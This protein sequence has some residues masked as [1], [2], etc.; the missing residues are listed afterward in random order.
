MLLK[1][2][3]ATFLGAGVVLLSSWQASSETKVKLRGII[4]FTNAVK[5]KPKTEEEI[6]KAIAPV[7]E[8]FEKVLA[9]E[10]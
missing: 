4:H 10:R 6:E 3:A 1:L 5:K 8:L 2:A 9:A 7:V